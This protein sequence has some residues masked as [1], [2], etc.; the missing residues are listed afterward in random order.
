M[1]TWNKHIMILHQYLFNMLSSFTVIAC[2]A[3]SGNVFAE[4]LNPD[5]MEGEG[6][7]IVKNYIV[8]PGDVLNV[9]VWKNGDLTVTVPVRPD[10]KIS[11]PLVDDI[12]AGGL[13]PEALAAGIAVKLA[14]FIRDPRVT[15]MV[16]QVNSNEFISRVRVTGAVKKP[17]S[18]PFKSGM[19][20]MDVVLIAGGLTDFA[21]ANKAKLYRKTS[22]DTLVYSIKLKDILNKGKLRTNIQL[23]P[24]DIITIP[25]R[26]L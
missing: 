22:N 17:V 26:L 1:P 9:S 4:S 7:S 21:S 25:E 5:S 13:T 10:G 18:L 6:A 16:T 15:V 23:Q 3:L 2:M 24:G 8:G 11:T 14:D 19:T 20:V 12:Q